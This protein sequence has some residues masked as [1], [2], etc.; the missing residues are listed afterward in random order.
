[1]PRTRKSGDGGL[2]YYPERDLWI[3]RFDNG[4]TPDGKRRQISVSSRSQSKARAK[5]AAKKAEIAA[6]GGTPFG[7]QTVAEWAE[8]WM[9]H[10]Q[11]DTMKPGPYRSYQSVLRTW[12]LPAIGRK[13]VKD[14]LP[15]DLRGIYT[16]IES[17][18]SSAT[19]LKAHI[20]MSS[21]FEAARLERVTSSNITKSIKPPKTTKT[22]RGTFEPATTM[23]ILQEAE[24]RRHGSKWIVSLYAG[25]RQ[26]ERL[27]ATLD[28]V[29]LE[30][31]TFTVRWNLVDGNYK[32]GCDGTCTAKSAGW[33]PKK[34]LVLPKGS[35]YRVL[36]GRVMLV[37]PKSGEPR[38]FPLPWPQMALLERHIAS[39]ASQP[40]PHG[41]LWPAGD[42][43]PMKARDDQAE[44]RQLLL[45]AGVDNHN[46]T[47]HWARHT[48][49]SDLAS[50]AIPD[51]TIGDM[52]GHKSAGVTG[53]Y[54]HLSSQDSVEA[55]NKLGARRQIES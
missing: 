48:A 26:G 33:C 3:A 22:K 36:S 10:V 45:D 6:N 14:V 19:A 50:L 29:D 9:E 43:S 37:P 34:K 31:G 32:H 40:N 51:R 24:M 42:G 8:Y 18:R 55:M 16:A 47:T 11:R 38:T 4:F 28:S 23:R 46:A 35:D 2:F 17:E 52:V 20:V 30:N 13:K 25:I 44:W 49:I 1:M 54:T 27:G 53:N 7:N 12:I 41:L 15:S 21:M 39:L 5:M